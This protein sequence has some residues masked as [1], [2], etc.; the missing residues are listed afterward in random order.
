[1]IVWATPGFAWRSPS[2]EGLGTLPGFPSYRRRL[3]EGPPHRGDGLIE[4]SVRDHQRGGEVDQV[5]ALV[6]VQVVT[7]ERR[8]HFAHRTRGKGLAGSR[9]AE[10]ERPEQAKAANL[11][12]VRARAREVLERRAQPGPG[13]RRAIDQPLVAVA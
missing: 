7:A 6:H 3:V 4:L 2:R 12:D 11:A 1:M 8:C 10:L 5:V 13:R 9:R